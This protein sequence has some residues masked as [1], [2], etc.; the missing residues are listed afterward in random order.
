[1]WFPKPRSHQDSKSRGSVATAPRRSSKFGPRVV[2]ALEDRALMS[3]VGFHHHMPPPPHTFFTQTNLVSD[4]STLPG[5]NPKFTDP[6]L[7]NPWGI[8]FG[9]TSPL[10]VADNGTGLSTLYNGAGNPQ[11]LVVTIPPPAGGSSAAPTGTV[12]NNTTGFVVTE[13]TKTG[14]SIFIFATEDGTISGWNPNVDPTNAILAVDN[15]QQKYPNGFT[16]AVYKGLAQA[17]TDGQTFIYATNFRSGHVDVFDKN[18]TNVNDT[19]MFKGKFSD[20]KIPKDFAPFGIQTINGNLY[21]TYAMQDAAHHDDVEGVGNGFV[22]VY[23]PNGTLIQR[24]ASRGS[25]DSPWGVTVAPAGFGQFSGALLVGNFGN[26][27]VNAFDLRTGKFLGQLPGPDGKPLVLNGGFQNPD[28]RDTK[29]L[30]GIAFDNGVSKGHPNTM[31]FTA[32]IGDEQHGLF[33]TLTAKTSMD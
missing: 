9:P 14:A 7:V 33:G 29:G 10:W 26:S 4:I 18:F 23:D 15:S 13:G 2:E 21:V 19:T 22:D 6:N 31:Y 8:A 25:L 5:G 20:P 1:M 16:G 32:G 3:H 24:V 12:F 30:W 17:S 11:S 27:H 28:P